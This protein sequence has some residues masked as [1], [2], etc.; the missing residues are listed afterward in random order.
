MWSRLS[1]VRAALA[2]PVTEVSPPP[3]R[4]AAVA[5]VLTADRDLLL[6]R[7]AERQGDAWS[8]QLAFPGGKKDPTDAD[9]LAAATREAREE[10]DLAL[11]PRALGGP[12]DDLM[13]RPVH[14]MLVRP[15][16]FV[17]PDRPPLRPNPE[18]AEVHWVSLDALLSGK[19]RGPMPY[20]WQG[21]SLTL[22]CVDVGAPVPLW[23]MSLR[24]V[25][26]LLHRIDGRG[27]GL[28]RR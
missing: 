14:D 20:S 17:L 16:V 15:Y 10:V 9:L 5:V 11:D 3:T 12:L 25:D 18:V 6:I 19:G 23:G 28:E 2:R 21:V 22:P 24:I 27:T 26:D 1:D 4:Q 8:G 13:A 7:R